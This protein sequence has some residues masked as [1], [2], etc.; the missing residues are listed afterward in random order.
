M[1]RLCARGG[2]PLFSLRAS[3]SVR[4]GQPLCVHGWPRSV[5]PV[6]YGDS[7]PILA[8]LAR[9]P[10]NPDDEQ[11]TSDSVNQTDPRRIPG[12]GGRIRSAPPM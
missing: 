2:L 10:H 3:P 4:H 8:T 9:V 1:A 12:V 7:G 5:I 6:Y 11:G